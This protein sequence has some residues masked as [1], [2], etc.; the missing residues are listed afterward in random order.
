MEV[1]LTKRDITEV[2]S[3]GKPPQD[4]KDVLL[5]TCILLGHPKDTDWKMIQRIMGDPIFINSI[6]NFEADECTPEAMEEARK[7]LAEKDLNQ[8]QCVSMAASELLKW[9]TSIIG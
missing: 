2:K 8:I 4:V 3:F 7:I 5:A 9:C 1:S 6:N